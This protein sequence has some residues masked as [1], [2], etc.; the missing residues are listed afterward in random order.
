MSSVNCKTESPSPNFEAFTYLSAKLSQLWARATPAPEAPK[1][2]ITL[3]PKEPTIEDMID[4]EMTDDDPKEM[5]L[6]EEVE[7]EK[8]SLIHI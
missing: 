1:L 7:I 8:L 4:I 5:N 3:Q 2:N 6:S